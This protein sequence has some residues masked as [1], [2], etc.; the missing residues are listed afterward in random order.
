MQLRNL[1]IKGDV[2]TC[3]TMAREMVIV[4]KAYPGSLT[5]PVLV[6]KDQND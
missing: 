5:I 2:Q 6:Q 3:K 4:Y 1:S